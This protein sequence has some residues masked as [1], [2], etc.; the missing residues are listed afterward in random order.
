MNTEATNQTNFDEPNLADNE[1]EN[2]VDLT[3]EDETSVQIKG[4]FGLL[5]P[6]V[7]K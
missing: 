2:V 4:G 5:L 1:T 3:V 6:A 7:Q